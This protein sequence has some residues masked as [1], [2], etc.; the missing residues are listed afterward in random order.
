MGVSSIQRS[1]DAKPWEAATSTTASTTTVVVVVVVVD[2]E[3]VVV[4]EDVVVGATSVGAISA[5]VV[6]CAGCPP[7]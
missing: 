2:E 3:V 4:V 5:D 6:S 1:D 7:N